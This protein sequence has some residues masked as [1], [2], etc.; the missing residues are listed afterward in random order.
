MWHVFYL[1]DRQP[2][3]VNLRH[4]PIHLTPMHCHQTRVK[5]YFVVQAGDL[6]SQTLTECCSPDHALP[7]H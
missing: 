5:F 6:L 1:T 7:F 2:V 3:P 4:R